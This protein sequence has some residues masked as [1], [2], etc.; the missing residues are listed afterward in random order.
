MYKTLLISLFWLI[1]FIGYAQSQREIDSLELNLSKNTGTDT[2]R[3]KNLYDLSY[4]YDNIDP[5]QG[6]SYAQQA[7]S[8]AQQLHWE[9]GMATSYT[10]LGINY[11][12]RSEHQQALSNYFK[13]LTSYEHQK[14][15][16]GIASVYANISLVYQVQ[17][18]YPKALDYDFRALRAHE[19]LQD[20]SSIAVVEE[21]IG[22]LYFERKDFATAMQYFNTA[23]Q[24]YRRMGDTASVARS[25][26]NIGMVLDASGNYKEALNYHRQALSINERH[27]FKKSEQINIEN[28]GYVYSHMHDYP[29]AIKY[30]RQALD[31]SVKQNIDNAIAVSVGNLGE[32]YYA[33]VTDT[34]HRPAVNKKQY[35]DSAISYLHCA[36]SICEK[37][38]FPGPMMEFEQYLSD[39]YLAAGKYKEALVHYKDYVALH[40]TLFS[41]EHKVRIAQLETDR[42]LKLRDKQI[43]IEQLQERNKRN[44]RKLFYTGIALLVVITLVML[45]L[46]WYYRRS[47]RVLLREKMALLTRI[48]IQVE[49]I[50]EQSDMLDDI[51]HTQSHDIR[52]P[53]AT[54]LGLSQLFN[55]DNPQDP[56]NKVTMQGIKSMAEK[57]DN[58]VKDIVDKE[59]KL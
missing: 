55:P 43:I 51:A 34:I 35:L 21:N 19:E 8:L 12:T 7:L 40:D 53:V 30:Q 6:I 16:K 42:Q 15:K 49:R 10:M 58:V 29:R 4:A 36:I 13:A 56:T 47:T 26:G 5:L 20:S 1:P 28:I 48:E 54:I 2:N 50:K 57:L 31:M 25:L 45:R 3:V 24:L 9:K 39:A 44:E 59:N 41:L 33:M 11:A 17:G 52:G 38:S 32:T 37:V 46:A 27:G 23:M 22:S 18:D 14:N